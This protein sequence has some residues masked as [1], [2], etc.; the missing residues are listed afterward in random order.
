MLGLRRAAIAN[1][2]RCA[3]GVFTLF[4]MRAFAYAHVDRDDYT[5]HVR[6]VSGVE[7]NS[8]LDNHLG[9]GQPVRLWFWDASARV[10]G[11]LSD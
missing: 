9:H 11:L 3:K 1:T 8:H 6:G 2:A 4:S 7:L 5:T 10:H